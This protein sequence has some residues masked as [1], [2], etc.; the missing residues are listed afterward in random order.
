MDKY[1]EILRYMGHH[2]GIDARMKELIS[3]SLEK[4][5]SESEPRLVTALFPCVVEED[6][7]FLADER[8]EINSKD[9]AAHLAGST[10]IYL[11]AATLGAGV[12]RLI[13]R[14]SKMDSAEA[15]CLQACAAFVIEEYC[16]KAEAELAAESG[17]EGFCLCPRFSP[18][19]GDFDLAHQTEILRLLDAPRKIGVSETGSHIL[20]PLKSVS[21]LIGGRAADE[22]DEA[23]AACRI[24]DKCAACGKIDCQFRAKIRNLIE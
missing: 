3:S 15:L 16:D 20:T 22:M 21:A 10:R 23:E 18:G 5:G 2:G 17:R 1:A 13:A 24:R 6:R 12:D 14:R 9:L 4:L 7:V 19:Y 11:L 8:L